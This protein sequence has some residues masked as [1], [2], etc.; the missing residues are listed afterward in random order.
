MADSKTDGNLPI[1][2]ELLK[3]VG[4]YGAMVVAHSLSRPASLSRC[5]Q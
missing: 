2:N 4:M 1:D 3:M 5:L